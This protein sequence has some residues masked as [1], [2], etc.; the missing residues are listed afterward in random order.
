MV[1]RLQVNDGNT[2]PHN[3]YRI[4]TITEGTSYSS[5]VDIAEI[6]AFDKVLTNKESGII[7]SY[8]FDKWG[9]QGVVLSSS[10]FNHGS[11]LPTYQSG[12]KFGD[13]ITFDGINYGKSI[14]SRVSSL[15]GDAVTLSFWIN[16]QSVDFH[17]F[18]VDGLPSPLRS[19]AQTAPRTTML[20]LDQTS[21]PGTAI[22]E[23][24][25]IVISLSMI[26]R[27]WC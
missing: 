24:G 27:I 22:N 26:G 8:L 5:S 15:Q 14:S 4:G 25:L 10:F 6:L 9:T 1:L 7:Q 18:N 17:L 19:V 3:D 12:S 13:G 21:L 16:P 20:G 11:G 23:F 2:G